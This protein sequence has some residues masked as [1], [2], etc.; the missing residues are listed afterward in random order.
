MESSKSSSLY[1]FR[2]RL[3]EITHN[4]AHLGSHRTYQ[5][6]RACYYWYGMRQDVAC[7]YRQCSYCAENK[8]PPLRLHGQLQK[9]PV[10]APMDLATMDILSV[11]PTASDR[12]K[13]LLV[14]VDVFY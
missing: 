14:M 7:W 11:L 3:F 5:Q 12:S 1:H 9:I 2:K 4:T 13:Y 6:L 8:G 10:G